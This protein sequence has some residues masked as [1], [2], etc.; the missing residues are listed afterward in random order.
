MPDDIVNQSLTFPD[1]DALLD[2]DQSAFGFDD[3][4]VDLMAESRLR[5]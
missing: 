3:R 2:L 5:A 4:D 1:R